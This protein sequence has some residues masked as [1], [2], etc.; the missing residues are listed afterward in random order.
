MPTTNLAVSPSVSTRHRFH[1]SPTTIALFHQCHQGCAFILSETGVNK[2]E[3][4]AYVEADRKLSSWF[5][6]R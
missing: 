2:T 5:F 6:I 4:F 3:D 1:A